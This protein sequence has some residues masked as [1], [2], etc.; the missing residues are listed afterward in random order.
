MEEERRI[1][2]IYPKRDSLEEF[3]FSTLEEEPTQTHPES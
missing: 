3:S 1:K 2:K